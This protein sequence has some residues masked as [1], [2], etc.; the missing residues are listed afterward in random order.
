[1][2]RDDKRWSMEPPRPSSV[3][4][5]TPTCA[6]ARAHT[7][8]VPWDYSSFLL[9][10]LLTFSMHNCSPSVVALSTQKPPSFHQIT[11]SWLFPFSVESCSNGSGGGG[12]GIKRA[13]IA[14]LR[15]DR[16]LCNSSQCYAYAWEEE[17]ND[18]LINRMEMRTAATECHVHPLLPLILSIHGCIQVDKRNYNFLFTSMME[19]QACF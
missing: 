12:G 11:V 1:M 2:E 18:A 13:A 10:Q 16:R 19:S 6:S 17:K 4:R 8:Y 15:A 7:T 9:L 3:L 5:S 14:S